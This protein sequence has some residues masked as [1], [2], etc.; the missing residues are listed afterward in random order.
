MCAIVS[1]CVCARV[2]VRLFVMTGS[3]ARE[4]EQALASVSPLG[5][6][7]IGF[8]YAVCLFLSHILQPSLSSSCISLHLSTNSKTIIHDFSCTCSAALF[9]LLVLFCSTSL[10]SS[11]SLLIVSSLRAKLLAE[12][13]CIDGDC[14]QI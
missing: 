11:P 12:P 10:S 2:C 5:N 14:C 1:A 9:L 8:H 7:Q 3:E 13:S 6:R 4:G